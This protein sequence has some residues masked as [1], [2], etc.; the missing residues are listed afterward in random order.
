M[1]PAHRV[2]HVVLAA[3][4]I[5]AL[6]AACG[7]D[8]DDDSQSD[9]TS[10][11]SQTSPT[12]EVEDEPTATQEPEEG[13]VPQFQDGFWTEGDVQANV[14]GASDFSFRASLY[15]TSATDGRTTRLVFNDELD[16]L[17][18]SISTQYQPFDFG[19]R[20]GTVLLRAG[21]IP[22]VVTYSAR[23]EDHLAGTFACEDVR[24][25]FSPDSTYELEGTFRATR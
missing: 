21:D 8:D 17:T 2:F 23:E 16:T 10:T 3:T 18:M 24:D 1:G 7:S 19:L 22:C 12:T 6:T 13:A 14:T 20:V 15:E 25:E 9:P 5:L 4:A 11:S